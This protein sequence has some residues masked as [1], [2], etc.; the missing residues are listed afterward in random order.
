MAWLALRL[1]E[2]RTSG[3]AGLIGGV[4]AAP[5]LLVAGA[6]FADDT[7]HLHAVAGSALLWM[8]IGWI[9]SRRATRSPIATWADYWREYVWIGSGVAIG[10]VAALVATAT[11]LGES[12]L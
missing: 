4:I 3:L 11:V 12:F 9:A 8:L 6:P 1:G 10:A 5:G 2:G 7:Y